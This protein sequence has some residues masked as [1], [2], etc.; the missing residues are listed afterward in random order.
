MPFWKSKESS[1]FRFCLLAS[2]VLLLSPGSAFCGDSKTQQAAV[3]PALNK[4]Q[5]GNK[6]YSLRSSPGQAPDPN[7]RQAA[8]NLPTSTEGALRGRLQ[9]AS[10]VEG[11]TRAP[12]TEVRAIFLEITSYEDYKEV[13]ALLTKTEGVQNVSL[14][15]EAP[16]LISLNVTYAGNPTALYDALAASTNQK[17][18]IK[19]KLLPSGTTELTFTKSPASSDNP[20][21]VH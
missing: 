12:T 3:S 1:H 16:G 4:P 5:R 6:R 10:P 14:D 15:S 13:R 20:P 7:P 21:S 9:P 8:G 11:A 17:F 18:S 2:A 19:Q